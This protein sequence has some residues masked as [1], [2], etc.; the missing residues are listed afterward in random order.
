MVSGKWKSPNTVK[1]F[2]KKQQHIKKTLLESGTRPQQNVKVNSGLCHDV[3]NEYRLISLSEVSLHE[4]KWKH[5]AVSGELTLMFLS[6]GHTSSPPK[7]FSHTGTNSSGVSLTR[8]SV[9]TWFPLL[10]RPGRP[11]LKY[12][13]A[14]RRQGT[15]TMC[16]NRGRGDARLARESLAELSSTASLWKKGRCEKSH[17]LKDV[18]ELRALCADI[19]GWWLLCVYVKDLFIESSSC[20]QISPA[21]TYIMIN[22]PPT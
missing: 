5:P 13:A 22:R 1:H 16:R 12:F 17:C 3:T 14:P 9:R 10:L 18:S 21:L 6:P 20:R 2:R 11:C 4:L 19:Y 15:R 7:H 8:S